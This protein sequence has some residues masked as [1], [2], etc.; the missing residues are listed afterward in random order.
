ME[1]VLLNERD[2]GP[3]LPLNCPKIYI[4]SNHKEWYGISDFRKIDDASKNLKIY[5]LKILIRRRNF[6][7]L[8][9][10]SL[11]LLHKY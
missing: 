9:K 5:L 10:N 3:N 1:I 2:F 4:K 6:V 11:E 7:V 8:V